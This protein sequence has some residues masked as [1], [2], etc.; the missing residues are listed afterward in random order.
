MQWQVSTT[1]LSWDD[2]KVSGRDILGRP[3]SFS[4]DDLKS[5]ESYMGFLTLKSNEGATIAIFGMNPDMNGFSE[6]DRKLT[7]E[8]RR[9]GLQNN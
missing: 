6:F 9:I 2:D 1:V 8:R 4:W 3:Q 5:V 7:V